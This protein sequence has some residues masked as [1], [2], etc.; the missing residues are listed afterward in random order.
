MLSVIISSDL[1]ES[2]KIIFSAKTRISVV[3]LK[4]GIPEVGEMWVAWTH[5]LVEIHV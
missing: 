4:I 3:L 2:Q 5:F 1:D